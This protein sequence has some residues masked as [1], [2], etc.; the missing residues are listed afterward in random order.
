M[1]DKL[2]VK[3]GRSV[4]RRRKSK[5][6]TEA[7]P[8]VVVAESAAS[9]PAIVDAAPAAEVTPVAESAPPEAPVEADA[10]S[11]KPDVVATVADE[12]QEAVQAEEERAM[13]DSGDFTIRARKIRKVSASKIQAAPNFV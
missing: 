12:S 9:E 2:S 6:S 11:T 1:S 8:E 3:K 5:A 4:V 10:P 7:P 13:D